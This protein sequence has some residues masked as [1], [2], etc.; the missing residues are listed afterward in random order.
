MRAGT[1]ITT[2]PDATSRV[3]TAPAPIENDRGTVQIGDIV[4]QVQPQ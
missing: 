2:A 4:H 1:S 3:T